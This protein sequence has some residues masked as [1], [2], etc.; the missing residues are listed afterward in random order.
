MVKDKSKTKP[1]KYLIDQSGK[2]E[3]TPKNTV[4]CLANGTIDTILI[5]AKI[6]RPRSVN[7]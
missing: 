2:I 3:Q 7:D 1:T 4:L 5:K 6:K